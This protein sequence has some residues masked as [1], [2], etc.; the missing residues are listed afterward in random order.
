MSPI[1][2]LQVTLGTAEIDGA[3]Q[4]LK[5]VSGSCE[6]SNGAQGQLRWQ[7]TGTRSINEKPNAFQIL[8]VEFRPNCWLHFFRSF[9]R[10]SASRPD[11]KLAGVFGINA[12]GLLVTQYDQFGADARAQAQGLVEALV[13]PKN[14]RS[15]TVL[16]VRLGLEKDK[17]IPS[18]AE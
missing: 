11:V 17:E 7:A 4:A 8:A 16:P 12:H 14:A 9:D 1:S 13:N 3:N 10:E 18:F 6:I 15:I 2:D 5:I